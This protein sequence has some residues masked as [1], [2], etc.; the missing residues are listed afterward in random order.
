MHWNHIV[1]KIQEI[2]AL[3]SIFGNVSLIILIVTKS[4]R[5]LGSYKYLMIYISIFEIL[6]SLIDVIIKPIIFSHGSTFICVST[7][8]ALRK[9]I[10]I[11]LLSMFGGFFGSFMGLFALQFMYRYLVACESKTLKTFNDSRIILW[12][13][14]PLIF[15][16]LYGLV[17]LFLFPPNATINHNIKSKMKEE[18]NWD[19]DEIAYIGPNLYQFS[20]NGEF[21]MNFKSL[22]GIL[23]VWTLV[24]ISFV[25][26][27]IF[28]IKCYSK[29]HSQM[30]G[31]RTLNHLQH[32]LFYALLSQTLIPFILMHLP[33]SI[34]FFATLSNF[35]LGNSSS[36]AAISMAM[37]PALDP[38]PVILIIKNNRNAVADI[39][40]TSTL[41]ITRRK[42]IAKNSS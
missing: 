11:Y 15:G 20:E 6:F 27:S 8:F 41:T 28:A 42:R 1:S 40:T 23:I 14:L 26:V 21:Q 25:T 30:D 17:V 19:I 7:N 34:I 16:L 39:V 35:D 24:T 22:I 10:G 32:Q 36:I 4:P 3:I 9:D 2:S 12:M 33:V 13:F 18:Y 29:M 38:L 37:F 5:Q 31:S